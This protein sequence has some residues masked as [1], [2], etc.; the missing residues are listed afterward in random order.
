VVRRAPSFSHT[1]AV[2][3]QPHP[4]RWY[5][6]GLLLV[7]DD[8]NGDAQR[9]EAR[10][11]AGAAISLTSDTAI[12]PDSDKCDQPGRNR[13]SGMCFANV[14]PGKYSVSV[15]A[16]DGYNPRE[17]DF[18]HGGQP[19]D[20]ISV[21]FGAQ[22]KQMPHQHGSKGP[23]P[24]WSD[25]RGALTGR[26]GWGRIPGECSGRNNHHADYPL[27]SF[28]RKKSN[29]SSGRSGLSR[30]PQPAHNSSNVPNQPPEKS[31]NP[32]FPVENISPERKMTSWCGHALLGLL[33]LLSL[34]SAGHGGLT[35][36]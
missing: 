3:P 34:F 28:I 14:P 35:S 32:A 11:I 7:Y 8:A 21:N 20:L 19:G 23:S 1:N 15:A 31:P 12:F 2:L 25:W 17:F 18:Q 5:R 16:P 9:Q 4:A 29:P 26:V 13:L 27:E 22:P 6:T 10:P 36:A 24:L 30:T 33:T